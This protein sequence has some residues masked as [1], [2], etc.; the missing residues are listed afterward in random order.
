MKKI[1]ENELECKL[2]KLRILDYQQRIGLIDEQIESIKKLKEKVVEYMNLVDAPLG[3]LHIELAR[4]LAQTSAE[5]MEKIKNTAPPPPPPNSPFSII[6][7]VFG[8]HLKDEN[9]Q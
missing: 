2:L 1:Q 3:T 8:I 7:D 4:I 9:D 6:N 5:Q